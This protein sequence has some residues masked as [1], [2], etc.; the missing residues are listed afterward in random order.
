LVTIWPGFAEYQEKTVRRIPLVRLRK[1][2]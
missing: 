2:S 1:V